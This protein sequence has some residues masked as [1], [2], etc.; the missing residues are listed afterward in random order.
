MHKEYDFYIPPLFDDYD[1]LQKEYEQTEK[2]C[3]R[4]RDEY[5]KLLDSEDANTAFQ[6]V[7][8]GAFDDF[9]N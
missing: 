7:S 1:K 9:I 4:V 3:Y 6:M 8:E 2:H 5:Q